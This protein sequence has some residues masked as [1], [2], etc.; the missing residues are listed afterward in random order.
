MNDRQKP[1][2]AARQTGTGHE[3]GPSG[4]RWNHGAAMP[5][6]VWILVENRGQLSGCEYRRHPYR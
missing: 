3:L 4:T 2:E 1:A 5:E 6:I